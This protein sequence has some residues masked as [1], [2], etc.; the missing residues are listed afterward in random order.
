MT[1]AQ[2]GVFRWVFGK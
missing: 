2:A 1:S